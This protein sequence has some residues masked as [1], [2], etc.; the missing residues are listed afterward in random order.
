ETWAEM[1]QI[2][3][4]IAGNR[5]PSVAGLLKQASD[6][7][8]VAASMPGQPTKMA[9]QVRSSG[10]GKPS[11]ATKDGPKPGPVVPQVVD[12]ESSL[13]PPGKE[14]AQTPPKSGPKRPRQ[15]LPTTTLAGGK[16]K[17]GDQPS[18]AE[19]NVEEAVVQQQDLLAEF[20]KIAD[21]LNR[22]LANLEG[23]TL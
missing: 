12:R 19:Q 23:S 5:M 18:P 1:L 20:E 14:A 6:A 3:R 22:V 8:R 4:D 21:E 7:P 11:E 15:G 9:G 10:A 2:L 16:S 17:P 13:Q